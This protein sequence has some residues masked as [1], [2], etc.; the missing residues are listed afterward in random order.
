MDTGV[1]VDVTGPKKTKLVVS[2]VVPIIGEVLEYH[3]EE[4]TPG[5]SWDLKEVKFIDPIEEGDE[6]QL[7]DPSNC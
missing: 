3:Q 2:A 1:M 7:P 5:Y 6:R 4:P